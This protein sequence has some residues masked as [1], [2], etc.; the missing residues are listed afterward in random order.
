MDI[1]SYEDRY[2]DD[3]I[4]L[5]A[6]FYDEA[7]NEWSAPVDRDRL[8]QTIEEHKHNVLILII[9]GKC[10]GVLAGVVVQS[11]LNGEKVYQEMIW[12]VSRAHRLNG[13]RFLK[14]CEARIKEAGIT[15][16][17][18]ALMANSKADKLKRLYER[19]NFKLFESHY[20]KQL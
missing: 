7:L 2:R 10:E 13:V 19:M 11:P 9:N 20:I 4:R 18:M 8:L 3:L 6:E 16:F 5:V 12:Y 17:I 14:A 1:S 15:Q